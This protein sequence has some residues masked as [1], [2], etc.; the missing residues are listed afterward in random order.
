MKDIMKP[1]AVATLLQSYSLIFTELAK[2]LLIL[3][4]LGI[5]QKDISTPN[6]IATLFNFYREEVKRNETKFKDSELLFELNKLLNQ[7]PKLDN[8]TANSIVQN[9]PEEEIVQNAL[10]ESEETIIQ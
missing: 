7:S 5:K 4:R 8:K 9:A 6:K 10:N 2:V 1:Q 3:E